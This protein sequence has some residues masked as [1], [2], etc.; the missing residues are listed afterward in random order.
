MRVGELT[1]LHWEEV[2][3]DRAM[4]TVKYNLYRLDGEVSAFHAQD[5]K[6]RPCDCLAAAVGGNPSGAEGM[7]G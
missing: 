6:Q 1:A 2:D 3:L 5:Q 4:I 7:A